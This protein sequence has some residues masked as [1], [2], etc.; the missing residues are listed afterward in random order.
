M[1]IF[2]DDCRSPSDVTWQEL[3]V[4]C[5]QI[6]RNYDDFV[7]FVTENGL[8][9]YVALDHDLAPEHYRE[10]MYNPDKHYNNYYTDGTFKI[11]TG[12]DCAKWLCNYCQ[13]KQLKF[14]KYI[15]H[16]MNPIGRTNILEYIRNWKKHCEV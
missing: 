11:K 12:Y 15:V 3:P 9:E 13:E 6:I 5:W 14:P 10:S 16:S 2:L 8:P 4:I 7:K 1:N